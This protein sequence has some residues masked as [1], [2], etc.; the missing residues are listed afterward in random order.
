VLVVGDSVAFS[1]AEDGFVHQESVLD[2]TTVNGAQIG[3]TMMRDPGAPPPPEA[4]YVEDC[5]VDWPGLVAEYEPDVVMLLFGAFGGINPTPIDGQDRW[6]CSPQYDRRW[7]QRLLES[8]DVLSA[9][10]A[11]VDLITAPTGT[12]VP[13][14]RD[15]FDTRQRC[16]N[17]VIEDV[18]E[19]SPNAQTI[20]LAGYIC[21][22]DECRDTIDGVYLRNDGLHFRD[23]GAL[24]VS[25]WLAPQLRQ[26]EVEV[27]AD[28]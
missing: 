7:R 2:L 13:G 4:T 26:V 18:A 1:L 14:D 17:T 8:V 5:S 22:E 11:V 10:G 27:G 24:L 20:D 6:P 3:C 12:L 21:P 16:I 15:Q 28:G 23:A 9:T 25:R 19:Q